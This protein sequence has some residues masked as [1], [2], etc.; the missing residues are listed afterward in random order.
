MPLVIPEF[1]KLIMEPIIFQYIFHEPLNKNRSLTPLWN[2]NLPE[3]WTL[4]PSFLRLP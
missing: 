4:R 2:A 1:S 3:V